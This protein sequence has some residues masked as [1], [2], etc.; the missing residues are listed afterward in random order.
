[1]RIRFQSLIKILP[2]RWRGAL[3]LWLASLWITISANGAFFDALGAI[4]ADGAGSSLGIIPIGFLLFALIS[5]EM[6]FVSL[7]IPLRL[8]SF[9][10]LS[11]AALVE[12]Y[13][14]QY[15]IVF[16]VTMVRNMVETDV[17]E[18]ADLMTMGVVSH[19]VGWALIPWGVIRWLQRGSQR[20]YDL[21]ARALSGAL[22]LVLLVVLVLALSQHF[23]TFFRVHRDTHA[24][25]NPVYPLYSVVKYVK[26]SQFTHN[27]PF[28]NV[29]THASTPEISHGA[30]LVILVV[31]ETA[32][33][34]HF[35]LNGYPRDTN[36]LLGARTQL[37]SYQEMIACGT[38][39]A[40][41]LPCM[42]SYL[43]R[44]DFDVEAARLQENVLDTLSA[45]GVEVLWRDNN[46]GS[47][48]VADRVTYEGRSSSS[49]WGQRECDVECRDIGMLQGLEDIL[50]GEPVDRLIVLHQMG[51]HGPAYYKRYPASFERF[52]PVCQSHDLAE[53]SQE[54]IINAYDNTI[55]YTDYFLDQTIGLLERFQDRYEVTFM[56]VGDHGESLGE[57]GV[58]LHGL[59]YAFAPDTQTRVPFL[60]WGAGRTDLDVEGS[61]ALASVPHSH[62]ELPNA[63]LSLFEIESDGY[64]DV[65]SLIAV[66]P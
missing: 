2:V 27:G 20:G 64:Q 32:R 10:F 43:K 39:T 56:Y 57:H 16:D 15:G 49:D 7:V 58:Y 9:I 50:R 26:Q 55:L 52:T 51:S 30:D 5:I 19:W 45:A 44:E 60:V 4:Y 28:V 21:R 11:V 17:R 41:S 48:H 13:Q 24:L 37:V 6:T 59:P 66:K 46:S 8:A 1:M 34:D 40:V 65:P 25:T 63:L 23:T 22:P 54:E 61:R 33:A 38:S 35:S 53:C 29:S 47:K 36:P 18:A 12:Y 31:G 3:E 14:S 62:D 42:F